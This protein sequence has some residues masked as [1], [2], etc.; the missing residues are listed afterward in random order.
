VIPLVNARQALGAV[1]G[2]AW[3]V[4][5]T[6]PSAPTAPTQGVVPDG[7]RSWLAALRLLSGVA[8]Q[9]IAPDTRLLPPESARFFYVDR[10]WTDALVQ[11]ALSVGTVTD[12]DRAV[13]QQ[14]YPVIRDDLDEAERTVRVTGSDQAETGAADVLTGMLLRSQAV[15]GWPGL[16]VR[17]YRDPATPDDAADDPSRLGIM[18]MEQLAPT[19]LLV[20]FDGVPAI[21]HVDEPRHGIQYGVDESS[22]SQPGN[23][24]YQLTFRT[25][26]ATTGDL[27]ENGTTVNVPFRANAPGVIDMTNLQG[28][29]KAAGLVPSP[30]MFALQMIRLPY[31]QVF[32]PIAD[33]TP[34]FTTLFRPTI[35]M[36]AIRAWP[37]YGDGPS[38]G[39]T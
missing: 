24:S 15:Q 33:A 11:G 7:A 18:R 25:N 31:R 34:T 13:L 26:A 9:H 36:E 38:T 20:I 12:A 30:S 28:D 3:K 21:V 35:A 39:S 5:V 27:T 6:P 2:A 32:G 4:T 1:W 16:H 23:W 29:I 14:V 19:V 10:A 37:G 8:F 22:G 17:G